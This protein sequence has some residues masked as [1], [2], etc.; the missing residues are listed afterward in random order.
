[1]PADIVHRIILFLGYNYLGCAPES[2]YRSCAMR[3]VV[4]IQTACK[5]LFKAFGKEAR[6]KLLELL[7]VLDPAAA[8]GRHAHLLA[9]SEDYP[10]VYCTRASARWSRTR[11]CAIGGA[12][13][14]SSVCRPGS[15]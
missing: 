8:M 13:L 14:W 2:F 6:H 9:L 5:L 3:R 4:C 11:R 10:D 15:T 1:M 7:G 12:V